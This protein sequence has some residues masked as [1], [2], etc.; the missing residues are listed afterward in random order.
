MET[1]KGTVFCP[2]SNKNRHNGCTNI[3]KTYWEHFPTNYL[4]SPLLPGTSTFLMWH[5]EVEQGENNAE[6]GQ[7]PITSGLFPLVS[8][9][10]SPLVIFD[11]TVTFSLENLLADYIKYI[12]FL[13]V[14]G[15][16]GLKGL[17]HL[18]SVY[19]VFIQYLTPC[20]P[21]HLLLQI[22]TG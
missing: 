20:F 1:A 21:F 7:T 4:G 14:C 3:S 16:D 11:P 13:E 12:L 10:F 15:L 5:R 2:I 22:E 9:F 8:P 17:F 18:T 6:E 19:F